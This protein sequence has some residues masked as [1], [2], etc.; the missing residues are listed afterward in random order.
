MSVR[1]NQ[2]ACSF[3]HFYVLLMFKLSSA[4][5]FVFRSCREHYLQAPLVAG[6]KMVVTMY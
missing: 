4:F 1:M 3:L 6:S 5:Y 2:N